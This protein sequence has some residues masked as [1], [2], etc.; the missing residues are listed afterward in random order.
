MLHIYICAYDRILYILYISLSNINPQT[1]KLVLGEVLLVFLTQ[2][3]VPLQNRRLI[4]SILV[5]QI[6]RFPL[7]RVNQDRVL[8]G[9]DVISQGKSE[10]L[11]LNHSIRLQLMLCIILAQSNMIHI[12][13]T[14]AKHW[15][16]SGCR[17][18]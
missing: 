6:C 16:T 12:A 7:Q 14:L 4:L 17:E 15:K 18:S 3:P 8:E 11:T 13:W 5:M 2:L 10:I 9:D 1:F